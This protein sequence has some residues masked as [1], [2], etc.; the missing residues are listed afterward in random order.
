ME[1][2]PTSDDN[3]QERLRAA[4][5][6]C[7]R[8]REENARL[9]TILGI[10]HSAT[11][12]SILQASPALEPPP[13]GTRLAFT[14]E[15]KVMLFRNLFRGREDIFA[16]RWEGKSGKS[17]YSP[18]GV[19]DWRAIHASRPEDRKKV[20]RKTRMLQPLSD[21]AIRNHLTGKQ[22]IGIYPLLPDET[23]WFLAVDFDKKSWIIDTAAFAATCR[24]F[25]I[26]FAVERSRSGNGAHVW[27]FFDRPIFAADAR[28][29]GCSLLTC[30]ME[31]RHE[32]GLDSYDRLF[33]NQDTMPKGGFGNLIALPLQ[34]LP[35]E[36]GNSVFLD[37]QFQPHTDQWRFLESIQRL[38]MDQLSRI[39]NSIS[40]DGNS[41]GVRLH[42]TDEDEGEAP[43]LLAPSRNR[44]EKQIFGPL[45]SKVRITV[46]NFVFIE[47]EGLSAAMID[48]LIRI[49][50]FQNPEF[51]KAQAMRLSTYG[52]PRVIS[53]SE[54]FPRHIGLPRGCMEE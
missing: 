53:C 24:K 40:P 46:S 44:K 52:K 4:Q 18:A 2:R 39:V 21:D 29:L 36:K 34:K 15:K 41:I 42:L 43:W 20:A 9:R 48:R 26:P 12:E 37:E 1:S 14:P 19:M 32:I 25:N 3:I 5:E 10:N 17:G 22:T 27:I 13:T 7:Q 38:P 49:A 50:A 45:P 33:P 31:N 23:C 30:T 8:L 47:K 54:L 16:I 35:R 11:N 51:Y 28:R 6:E